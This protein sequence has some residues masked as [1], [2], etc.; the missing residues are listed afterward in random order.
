MNV[1][2][3]IVIL[4]GVLIII[5]IAY[6]AMSQAP[7][8]TRVRGLFRQNID[9]Q[10]EGQR[11]PPRPNPQWAADPDR[12][13]EAREL[14]RITGVIRKGEP[15]TIVTNDPSHWAASDFELQGIVTAV[16]EVQT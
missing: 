5:L 14:E 3:A 8:A 15:F 2:S 6:L 10:P 9:N 12:T 11:L 16:A 13:N 1:G 7:I 4:V